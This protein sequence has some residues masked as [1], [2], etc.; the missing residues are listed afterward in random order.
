MTTL[1]DRNTTIPTRKSEVFS[2]A[3]DNQS[4]VDIH[5][6]QGERPMARDNMTL[7]RFRLEGIPPAPRG[8]PQ[9][10]VEFDIDANGILH[11]KA[12]DKATGREQSIRI[13]ASTNLAS[14]EIDRLVRDAEAHRGE[15]EAQRKQVE[16][17]N[18]ADA[19]AYQAEKTLRDAE[20]APEALRGDVEAR[21]KDVRDALEADDGAR[22]E[23]A[24]GALEQALH[25]LSTALYSAQQETEAQAGDGGAAAPEGETPDDV[26]EGEFREA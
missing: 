6:L 24:L 12:Q 18:R 9:I 2:T 16:L 8:M 25:A 4:A 13:T 7:G 10:E 11:V 3:E 19:M 22:I 5:V 20:K 14:D 1:I 26:V 17:R 23:S 21:V 15:D